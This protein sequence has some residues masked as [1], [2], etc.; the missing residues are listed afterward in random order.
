MRVTIT[1]K[2]VAKTAPE[3]SA[4][5]FS[6]AFWTDTTEPWVASTPTSIRYRIDD[7]ET[8]NN[9]TDWTTVSPAT[10]ATI[11]ATGSNNTLTNCQ[12]RGYRQLVVEADNGLT[13][14]CVATH[15]Y[16]VRPLV[17]VS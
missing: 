7:P 17:G 14:A 6:V 4:V 15:D 13:T 2:L 10:T 3:G 16:Y 11:T 1:S 9:L 8:G 5:P 12:S